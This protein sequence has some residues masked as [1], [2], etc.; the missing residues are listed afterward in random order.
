MENR[1]DRCKQ[2]IVDKDKAIYKH[3]STIQELEN[4]SLS[5]DSSLCSNWTRRSKTVRVARLSIW[6]QRSNFN[7]S[8]I[9]QNKKLKA[10]GV[11]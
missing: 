6:R 3:K 11:N 8:S 4:V 10:I 1:L 9:A 2:E 7:L 5:V